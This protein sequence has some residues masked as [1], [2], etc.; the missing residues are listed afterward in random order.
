MMEKREE[1]RKLRP[2]APGLTMVEDDIFVKERATDDDWR[3]KKR[4][5]TKKIKIK[6]EEDNPIVENLEEEPIGDSEATDDT[7]PRPHSSKACTHL[8]KTFS[9]AMP[10]EFDADGLVCDPPFAVQMLRDSG[11][12]CI[13]GVISQRKCVQIMDEITSLRKEE[14]AHVTSWRGLGGGGPSQKFIWCTEEQ[15][16]K[17]GKKYH[18]DRHRPL[19]PSIHQKT[20]DAMHTRFGTEFAGPLI[21]L[22]PNFQQADFPMHT[23]R[24]DLEGFG[25]K[26][27]TL[28]VLG[29]GWIVVRDQSGKFAFRFVVDQGDAWGMVGEAR[30]NWAHGVLCEEYVSIA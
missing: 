23:D 8:R 12:K 7:L 30:W 26:I 16:K 1:V 25:N 10:I 3:A 5:I 14:D 18:F 20:L 22:Q 9:L 15:L 24:P 4:K 19:A 21:S 29:R 11:L 28:G 17:F 27:I 2:R 6:T 13:R